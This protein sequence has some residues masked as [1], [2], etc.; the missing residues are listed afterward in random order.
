MK[1]FSKWFLAWVVLMLVLPVSAFAGNI[2]TAPHL[3]LPG[4]QIWLA[5]IGGLVPLFTYV[6]NHVGPWVT[7]PIKAAVL[8]VITAIV[9]AL[10]TAITTDQF[11]WN[12]TTWQL[13]LTAVVAALTAHKLLWKPSGISLLLGGGR[14][15]QP[16][17]GPPAV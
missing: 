15:K 1:F 8:V 12:A 2:G 14:N 3:V 17:A 10:Y 13:M 4:K 11:G 6:L 7:E 9:G 5:L 16:V